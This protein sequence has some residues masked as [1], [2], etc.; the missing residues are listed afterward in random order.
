M[1]RVT[2]SQCANPTGVAICVN[3]VTGGSGE[4]SAN[5]CWCEG[6][7]EVGFVGSVVRGVREGVEGLVG[8]E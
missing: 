6:T 1:G 7:V 4:M 8:V 5:F 2:F 3:V